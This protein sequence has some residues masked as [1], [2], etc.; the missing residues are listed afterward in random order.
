[1]PAIPPTIDMQGVSEFSTDIRETQIFL[2]RNRPMI[3]MLTRC[4]L[5][6]R[7]QNQ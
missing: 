3:A 4:Q 5:L 6:D 7:D 2:D 1:M